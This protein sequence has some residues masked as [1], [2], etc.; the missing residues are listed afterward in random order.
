MA[1]WITVRDKLYCKLWYVCHFQF[2][3]VFAAIEFVSYWTFLLLLSAFFCYFLLFSLFFCIF[4]VFIKNFN[5]FCSRNLFALIRLKW[6]KMNTTINRII[7]TWFID[8]LWLIYWANDQPLSICL[9]HYWRT[10][11]TFWMVFFLPETIFQDK[12]CKN[13]ML[14]KKSIRF[15]E[16]NSLRCGGFLKRY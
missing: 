13:N 6:F 4:E 14:W 16:E 12:L 15:D 1:R 9:I 8:Y 7:T 2:N 5:Y 11:D 3:F 10:Y